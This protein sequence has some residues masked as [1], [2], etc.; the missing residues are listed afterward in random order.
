MSAS[1]QVTERRGT[2]GTL[3]G[4]GETETFQQ[5]ANFSLDIVAKVEGSMDGYIARVTRAPDNVTRYEYD[6]SI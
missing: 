1:A 2:I 5:R 3:K 6:N 4:A